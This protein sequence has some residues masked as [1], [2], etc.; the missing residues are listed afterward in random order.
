MPRRNLHWVLGT[1][2]LT[3]AC[4]FAAQGGL[5][6]PRGPLGYVKGLPGSDLDYE[7]LSLFI[8]VMQIVEQNYVHEL[9]KDERRKFL[10]N[11]I[12][13]ALHGLDEHSSYF[14]PKEFRQFEKVSRGSFG[15]IGVQISIS[16]DT[17]KLVVVSPIVGTPAYNAGIKPGDEIEEIDG[18]S[19][20]GISSEDAVEKITGQPGTSIRLKVRSRGTNRSREVRLTRAIIEVDSVM[21]DLRDDERKWD[22]MLDPTHR[23]GY[24]RL[25]QFGARAVEEMKAALENLKQNKARALILDLRGNPGGQLS[26]AVEIANMFL[27]QG[28][29]VT[30]EGRNRPQEVHD[31]RPD[32]V[33]PLAAAEF[34]M[35]VLIDGGSASASEIVAAAMQ[36]WKRAT[37][38]GER[39]YGKGS[40][41][42]LIQVEGGS[43]AVKVTTAKYLRPSGKN[44]HRFPTSTDADD[45]GVRPDVEIKLTPQE[46]VEQF[47]ARRD[48]DV[49]RVE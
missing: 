46:E 11:A 8:D 21:G 17:R 29:I 40:V 15:G 38:F 4:W 12:Q 30:V 43:S 20:Q 5:A 33:V 26:G 45:W 48:R 9:S 47:L 31:A 19:T 2:A 28:R 3:F 36:D 32:H 25:T 27:A 23:I 18:V 39:T 24:V 13:A 44:I 34:P 22:Y 35:V 16:R 37:L 14:S 6:G 42:N 10:E 49:V 41:Q 7:S 1:L